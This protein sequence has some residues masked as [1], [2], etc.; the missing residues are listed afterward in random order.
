MWIEQ[1]KKCGCSI[2]PLLKEELVG[3]CAIHGNEVLKRYSIPNEEESQPKKY[4]VTFKV[5]GEQTIAVMAKN[6]KEAVDKALF[7][8]VMDYSFS[9]PET[10]FMILKSLPSTAI[11][12]EADM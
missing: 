6:K 3:Y 8:E 1:Y 7:Q 12:E 4:I 2:G 10:D 9:Q 11:V 5:I